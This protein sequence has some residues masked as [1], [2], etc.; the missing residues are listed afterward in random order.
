MKVTV[1]GQQSKLSLWAIT[2]E[3]TSSVEASPST[4]IASPIGQCEAAA[5]CSVSNA[6]QYAT[7]SAPIPFKQ[8]NAIKK[9]ETSFDVIVRDSTMATIPL[10]L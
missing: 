7:Q 8:T 9:I 5:C 1:S 6:W 4:S 3:E 2:D 10:I